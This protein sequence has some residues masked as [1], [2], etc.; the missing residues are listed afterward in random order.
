MSE[1]PSTAPTV[2]ATYKILGGDQRE[3]GPVTAEQLCAWIAQHR[4]NGQTLVLPEGTQQWKPLSALPEFSAALAAGPTTPPT[5][6]RPAVPVSQ[7][8]S[9]L[10][11][12]SLVLGILGFCSLGLTALAGFVLGLVS[13]RKIK[14][15][16]GRLAGRGLAIAGTLVSAV[17]M[18]TILTLVLLFAYQ[19]ERIGPNGPKIRGNAQT[20]Q[21]V[22]NLKQIT[23]VAHVYS[24]EHQQTFPPAKTWCDI[25]QADLGGAVAAK[26]FK[27]NGDSSNQRCNYGYNARLS[28]VKEADVNPQT[29]MFFEIN[30]GWNV[31]GGPELLMNTFRHG[32]II[33]LVLADSSVRQVPLSAA[34]QLRW[35]P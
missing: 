13:L 16:G 4:A 3:Y 35:N 22:N 11:V 21:C 17:A 1:S 6:A 32:E 14:R 23:L 2:P 20:M 10:A 34:M 27:C 33:N 12:T 25:L 29:V 15:S 18:L 5:A 9:G 8:T 19:H 26:I 31:S 7:T 30:G 28:G 24:S